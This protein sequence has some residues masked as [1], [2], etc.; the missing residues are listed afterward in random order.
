MK[1]LN[2]VVVSVLLGGSALSTTPILAQSNS[3]GTEQGGSGTKVLPKQGQS[4]SQTPPATSQPE[5]QGQTGTTSQGQTSTPQS[6]EGNSQPSE[7]PQSETTTGS[8][9][10]ESGSGAAS[11]S[12]SGTGT[13]GNAQQERSTTSGSEGG[14]T[15]APAQSGQSDTSSTTTE[16]SGNVEITTEQ[17]TEIRNV[18]VESDVEPATVDFDINVGVAVPETVT[19][20]PLPPRIIELVP[21]YRNYVYFILADGRIVIV[22]PSSHK[23]VYIIA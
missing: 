21:A 22:E 8:G 23:V 10:A 5:A 11:G 4:G 15:G 9:G 1:I 12:G 2:T 17:R 14:T 18:I 20:H 16:T 19:L 7:N 3:S 13:G 6:A